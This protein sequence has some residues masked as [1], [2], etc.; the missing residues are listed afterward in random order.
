MFNQHDDDDDEDD[1]AEFRNYQSSC[2]QESFLPWR[3]GTS[4]EAPSI[5]IVIIIHNMKMMKDE[6]GM[7]V[8]HDDHHHHEGHLDHIKLPHEVA[9]LQVVALGQF[10]KALYNQIL[11]KESV[12]K[13]PNKL[14]PFAKPPSD[15]PPPRFGLF[16]EKK[17]TSYLFLKRNH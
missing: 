10:L 7:V 17:L 8:D 15:S 6:D 1:L 14:P 13:N 16:S 3:P 4:P 12:E 9:V 5:V 11:G 2:R